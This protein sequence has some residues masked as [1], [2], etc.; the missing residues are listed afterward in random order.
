MNNSP[1]KYGTCKWHFTTHCPNRDQM[2]I[3][4]M[5][6]LPEG[7]VPKAYTAEDVAHDSEICESCDKYEKR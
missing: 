7:S 4:T 1:N 5:N 3:K 6:I 2:R